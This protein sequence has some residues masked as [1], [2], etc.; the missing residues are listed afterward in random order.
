MHLKFSKEEAGLMNIISRGAQSVGKE[1]YLIGGFVRDKI[2]GRGCK[3]MDIVC[4]GD[5]IELAHK[6]A[7]LF[8]HKPQVN[9]FKNFGTAHIKTEN[10]FDIEFWER[11]VDMS[12]LQPARPNEI[13]A[14]AAACGTRREQRNATTMDMVTHWYATN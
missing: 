3:D 10:G 4:V 14:N 8:P 5:A 1:A 13:S 6:V 7:D 11:R 12:A 2:L 9:Y